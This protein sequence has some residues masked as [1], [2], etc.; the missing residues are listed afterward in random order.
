MSANKQDV[1]SAQVVLRPASG[2]ALTPESITAQNIGDF[3][4]SP[5]TVARA[6]AAL[7]A[8]GF[9]VGNVVGNS[10][11][12]TGPPRTFENLFDVRVRPTERGGVT[13]TREG[14]PGTYELPVDALPDSVRDLVEAVT[15]TPPPDFGPTNP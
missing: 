8:M 10:F 6:T 12:I 9:E 3:A 13:A 5:D 7:R 4:P 14:G 15:F 2:K 11:S 1:I